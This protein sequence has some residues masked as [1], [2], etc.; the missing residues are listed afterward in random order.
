MVYP[1]ATSE[2]IGI[3]LSK[4]GRETVMK[5]LRAICPHKIADIHDVLATA[6]G[7]EVLHP[8]Q[9]LTTDTNPWSVRA[10]TVIALQT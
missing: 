6:N 3:Q 10:Y 2:L 9:Q 4:C 1:L 7:G 5:M 8:F